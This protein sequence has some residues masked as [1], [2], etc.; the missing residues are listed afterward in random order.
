MGELSMS[1]KQKLDPY[2]VVLDDYEKDIE[3]ALDFDTV[4]RADNVEVKIAALKV[5]AKK[6]LHKDKEIIIKITSSDFLRLKEAA[7]DEGLSYQNLVASVLHKYAVG[8]T[9]HR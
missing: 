5:A 2:D 3:D 1:S 7:A 9:V 8:Q 6:Y 4:E